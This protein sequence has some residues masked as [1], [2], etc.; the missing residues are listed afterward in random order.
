M[1]HHLDASA[2]AFAERRADALGLSA[3]QVLIASDALSEETYARALARWLGVPFVALDGVERD[4]FLGSDDQLVLS[5]GRGALL[6]GAGAVRTLVVAPQR[7]SARHLVLTAE[8]NP[9]L[10]GAI[11]VTTASR[12]RG[13]VERTCR[14][15]IDR[16][17]AEGLAEARPQLSA[18]PRRA[19]FLSGWMAWLAAYVAA[20]L[21]FPLA[22]VVA[23]QLVVTLAFL[24]WALLR[25]FGAAQSAGTPASVRLRHAAL[26]IY[27]IIVALRRE[28]S[29][30]PSLLRAL[31]TLNYPR[32]KLDVKFVVEQ[33]D[34]AT[35]HA[36]EAA[37]SDLPFEIIA[38]PL[39]APRT[40]PKALNV[41]L[42]FARG[43][44]TVVYDAEDRPEP[45]QLRQ[46]LAA[47]FQG[48]ET[49]ACVQ[50]R[51]TIDNT[52][53]GWLASLFTAEYA[54]LFDVLLPG[55][56]RRGLPIPLGGSSNHFRTACLREAGGWDPYNVTEDAD[57]GTRLARLGFASGV[58]A[59][60]TYE[61]APAR[62][63][64]WLKQRTRWFKGWLQTWG[65]HMRHPFRLARD[66]GI[67]GFT[68][69]QFMLMGTVF[70]ALIQP[71]AVA[72]LALSLVFDWS[73]LP[74]CDWAAAELAWV[75]GGAMA[76]GYLMSMVL[77]GLGLKRRGLL[78]PARAACLPVW[79][80]GHWVLLSVAAWRAAYQYVFDRYGWEKT[81]HG[82]ARTSRRATLPQQ[83]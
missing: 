10:L 58:I 28:A 24:G 44:Y 77:A 16:R 39:A 22:T 80:V 31:A 29:S 14:A 76:A 9:G 32:E 67:G 42:P 21:T 73:P 54:G 41:A 20:A 60:T 15:D 12:L 37:S 70:A 68:T 56:A 50:A 62:L 48:P 83:Y 57:L 13:F 25:A 55:L 52:D 36:L 5:A 43:A 53:D 18:A 33:D 79:M 49:L 82:L 40:K 6:L 64:P 19:R 75:H 74:A 69:F 4:A 38:A 35:R 11:S 65:V 66:L 47:F 51:L 45:D 71:V 46:A 30:V 59:S 23:T 72:L 8:A 1:R 17:A 81:E 34:P 3:D 61:E 26:P 63:G 27:T 78:T 7:D 2:V